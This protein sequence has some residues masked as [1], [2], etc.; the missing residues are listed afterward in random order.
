LLAAT[1]SAS[2]IARWK[3]ATVLGYFCAKE[4]LV[5]QHVI[6]KLDIAPVV[7]STSIRSPAAASA[8]VTNGS[9]MKAASTSFLASACC[10]LGKG[11]TT[12]V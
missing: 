4:A 5:T 6:G 3:A 1:W 8:I 11:T 12:V 7:M 2:P 9:I 10:A